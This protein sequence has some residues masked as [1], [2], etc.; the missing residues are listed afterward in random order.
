MRLDHPSQP[1]QARLAVNKLLNMILLK[2]SKGKYNISQDRPQLSSISNFS[3][4]FQP[5]NFC[6]E[7]VKILLTTA[8]PI[9]GLGFRVYGLGFRPG[10]NKH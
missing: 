8:A 2:P 6:K 10:H 1:S 3:S 5:R 4:N 7:S 9:L